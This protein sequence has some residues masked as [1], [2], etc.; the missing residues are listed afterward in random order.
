MKMRRNLK[1]GILM[2]INGLT[3][4]ILIGSYLS[5]AYTIGF[6]VQ[7][8]NLTGMI[9]IFNVRQNSEC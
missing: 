4:A 5:V 6:I 2:K 8:C 9:I 3:K 1:M 7:L